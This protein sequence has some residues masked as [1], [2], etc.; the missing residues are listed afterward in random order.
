[1]MSETPTRLGW[2]MGF[3]G[4]AGTTLRFDM[5]LSSGT[6]YKLAEN[7][8]N[9]ADNSW[10]TVEA[11]YNGT[12][13]RLVVDGQQGTVETAS[14]TPLSAKTLLIGNDDCCPGRTLA[15]EIK[16][17]EIWALNLVAWQI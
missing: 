6:G 7:N 16:D 13:I 4:G 1:M 8:K 2:K 14:F 11:R 9:A 17:I 10:H 12:A 5:A 3:V 15:G